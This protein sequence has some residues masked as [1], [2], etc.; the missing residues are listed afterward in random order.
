ML[1][2]ESECSARRIRVSRA[3]ADIRLLQSGNPGFSLSIQKF[4]QRGSELFFA[5]IWA[6]LLTASFHI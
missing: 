6:M 5:P 1:N 3:P 4:V 2:S